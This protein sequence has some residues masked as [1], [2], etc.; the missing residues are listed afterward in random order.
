MPDNIDRD[1]AQYFE[2]VFQ[3]VQSK[4]DMLEINM[5]GQNLIDE[6]VR[7]LYLHLVEFDWDLLQNNFFP[8]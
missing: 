7:D 4:A 8:N 5:D 3:E 2:G 1:Q 6:W